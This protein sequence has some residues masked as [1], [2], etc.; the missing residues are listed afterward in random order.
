MSSVLVLWRSNAHLAGAILAGLVLAHVLAISSDAAETRRAVVDSPP[1]VLQP[2][3]MFMLSNE[4]VRKE[5]RTSREQEEQISA[6]HE[7]YI[8]VAPEF[9]SP[10][11]TPYEDE[12]SVSADTRLAAAIRRSK[13]FDDKTVRVL[14]SDQV[15]RL[16]QLRLQAKRFWVVFEP[17][18]RDA[19]VI[20]D[21]TLA[22]AQRVIQACDVKTKQ[23]VSKLA[24]REI[25]A[26]EATSGVEPEMQA[27]HR[28]VLSLLTPNQYQELQRLL[29]ARPSFNPAS[30]TY[31]LSK[32]LPK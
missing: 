27:A 6:I 26:E 3:Y 12:K 32:P 2:P 15:A 28:E 31:R 10:R 14:S 24:E 22:N 23:W 18:V 11:V 17:T 1:I 29:G 25:S 7:E 8:R 4:L 19:L 30:L 20:N 5:L 13:E 21:E 9:R 16:E